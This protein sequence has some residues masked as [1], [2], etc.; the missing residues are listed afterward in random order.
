MQAQAEAMIPRARSYID[1]IYAVDVQPFNVRVLDAALQAMTGNETEAIR[2][3]G[4]AI[5][6]GLLYLF[7]VEIS[8]QF[9]ALRALPGYAEQRERLRDRIRD[10]RT[11]LGLDPEPDAWSA[12]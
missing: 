7:I 12:D 10:I 5:D 8:P 11:E 2:L 3:F 1:L 9:A 6:E 4:Q